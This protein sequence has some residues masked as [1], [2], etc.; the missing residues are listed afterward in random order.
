VVL[1]HAIRNIQENNWKHNLASQIGVI[2]ERFNKNN[3]DAH[4][5]RNQLHGC[6]QHT[7]ICEVKTHDVQHTHDFFLQEDC[8]LILNVVS[9]SFFL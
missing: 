3:G 2:L 8:A 6:K 7:Y 1:V 5:A 4:Q 9:Q